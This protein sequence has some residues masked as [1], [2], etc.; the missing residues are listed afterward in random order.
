MTLLTRTGVS[1]L[2]ILTFVIALVTLASFLVTVLLFGSTA[3]LLQSYVSDR[4]I[5]QESIFNFMA[6]EGGIAEFRCH[7]LWALGFGLFAVTPL[8][9]VATQGKFKQTRYKYLPWA[10][11]CVLLIS[12]MILSAV[13]NSIPFYSYEYLGQAVMFIGGIG[14]SFTFLEEKYDR[15]SSIFSPIVLAGLLIRDWKL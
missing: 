4:I 11:G 9:S 6:I 1:E 14:I 8:I 15:L 10:V 3:L 12:S 5:F 13:I 2:L 7:C